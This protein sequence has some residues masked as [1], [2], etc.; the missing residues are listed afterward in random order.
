VGWGAAFDAYVANSQWKSHP[1]STSSSAGDATYRLTMRPTISGA[2]VRLQL[3]NV[4]AAGFA[5]S[6]G[7]VAR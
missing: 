1:V 7:R 5:V 2:G 4:S 3:V 6:E